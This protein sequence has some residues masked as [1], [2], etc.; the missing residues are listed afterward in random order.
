[1]E[2]AA[3]AYCDGNAATP[4]GQ[5]AYFGDLYQCSR[6]CVGELFSSMIS[7]AVLAVPCGKDTMLKATSFYDNE[8]GFCHRMVELA[9]LM[10]A[11]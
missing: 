10:I 11:A 9:L 6:D 8:M 2:G 5:V 3:E 7:D 4:L 1:M